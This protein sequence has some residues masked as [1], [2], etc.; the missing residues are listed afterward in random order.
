LKALILAAGQGR[1]QRENGDSKPLIP[2]LGLS[3]V[4][5]VILTAKK[6]GIKEFLIVTGYNAGKVRKHLKKGNKLGVKID[7]VY[8]AEWRKGNGVSVLKAKDYIQEPFILLM[9]D[10]LFDDKILFELQQQT[11]KDDTCILCVDKNHHKYLDLEDATKVFMEDGQIKDIGKQLNNYNGIDT[12][13]FL[14]TPVIFDALE[15]SINGGDESLAAGMK[16]L[17]NRRKMK[18]FDISD[19]YWLDVDDGSALK[20][21]KSMLIQQL[22][23]NTDGPISRILNR[24]ISIK[25]SELLLK[26]KITPNQISLVSFITAFFG[27]LFF[28]VGEYIFLIIGGILVQLSSIIDGCDG[29]VARLKLMQTKYGGWFDAVLDRYAD[30]II[31]FGMIHGH[32]ILHNNLIIWT[33]GFIAL[34]GSFLNSYTADKYDAIFKKRRKEVNRWRMGRDIR[35]FLI[36]IG[37]LSNQILITLVVLGIISNFEAIKRLITL[38][39]RHA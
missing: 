21:A 12:G 13:I 29:E 24:P 27:A 23:K 31:I 1:R 18:G 22:R 26:T 5:R 33:I 34:V 16:I 20:N 37:A 19:R 14:C 2:L 17:A 8:N 7:Y 30:A 9:A 11:I 4:E 35:L 32:W 15:Q 25:I 6:S 38:R 39:F 36:F 28:Y 3:F 10:H